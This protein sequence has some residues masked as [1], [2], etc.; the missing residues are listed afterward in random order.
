MIFFSKKG[1]CN[2][3]FIEKYFSLNGENLLQKKITGTRLGVPQVPTK[4][5]MVEGW[6]CGSYQIGRVLATIVDNRVDNRSRS[7]P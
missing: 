3:I 2:R 4:L 1:I 7:I 6:C 5:V